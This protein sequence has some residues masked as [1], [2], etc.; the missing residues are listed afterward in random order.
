MHETVKS[1]KRRWK[2]CLRLT[3]HWGGR[4]AQTRH[5]QCSQSSSHTRVLHT[6]GD[7]CSTISCQTNII[8]FSLA[9][10]SQVASLR[11]SCK[12]SV[13]SSL[14]RPWSLHVRQEIRDGSMENSI[15]LLPVYV[16][17]VHQDIKDSKN[18]ITVRYNHRSEVLHRTSA[19]KIYT[20]YCGR[21]D[22]RLFHSKQFVGQSVMTIFGKTEETRKSD[23][24]AHCLGDGRTEPVGSWRRV[25]YLGLYWHLF[26]YNERGN[27]LRTWACWNI[28]SNLFTSRPTLFNKSS[29]LNLCLD[30]LLNGFRP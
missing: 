8:R 6:A 11:R 18:Y 22:T 24:T 28:L 17:V 27:R 9:K 14:P 7:C 3:S 5:H 2:E 30:V 23:L 20:L 29:S 13:T 16:A 19:L 25:C 1:Q 15:Q 21:L 26:W 4:G 12:W 10:R